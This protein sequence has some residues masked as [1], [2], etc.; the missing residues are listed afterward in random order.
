[1]KLASVKLTELDQDLFILA[2][3]PYVY[4]VPNTWEKQGWTFVDLSTIDKHLLFEI[5]E[6]AYHTV[7]SKGK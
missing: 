7:S 5:I 4:P 3:T 1:M 2:G 6:K